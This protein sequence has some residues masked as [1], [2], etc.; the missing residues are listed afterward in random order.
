MALCF[1]K[2]LGDVAATSTVTRDPNG[3]Y[4]IVQCT[5]HGRETVIVSAHSDNHSDTEQADFYGRL[6]RSLPAHKVGVDYFF[7]LDAN[8]AP[9]WSLDQRNLSVGPAVS[10]QDRPL[11]IETMTTLFDAYHVV[12]SFRCLQP[13]AFES[14]RDNRIDGKLTCQKRLDRVYVSRHMLRPTGTPAVRS[15]RHLWPEEVDFSALRQLGSESKWSDHA[16]VACSVRYTNVPRAEGRWSMPLHIL[17]ELRPVE[18]MREQA[19]A[20]NS[21]GG[22]AVDNLTSLMTRASSYVKDRVE[23]GT[24]SHRKRKQQLIGRI[25][26]ANRLL[27]T[28]T[29]GELD[30]V[31]DPVE[32]QRRRD[33]AE[34]QRTDADRALVELQR[35]EQERWARD[36]AYEQYTQ[37]GTCSRAFFEDMRDARV[38][39]HIEKLRGRGNT[40]TEM[41][42]LLTEAKRYFGAPGSIFNLQRTLDAEDIR[43]RG[44]LFDALR[45]DNRVI[46]EHLRDKLR[47]EALFDVWNVQYAIEEMASSKTAG[48]DGI[49]ADWFKV[50]GK[51]V[52][53]PAEEEGEMQ[54][55]PSPLAD[56]MSR[57]FKQI[58]A[59]AKAPAC[60]RNAVVSLLYK[61]K[62]YRYDLKNYRPIAV[63]NAIGKILEKAMVISMRP[64]LDYIVSPEQK[65]FQTRKYIA[66][67]TQ[68]VQDVIAHCDNEKQDGMLV[69]CDQDSAY[70]R[71]EWEFMT[72]TM[73][74]MGVHEDFIKLVNI[75]YQDSTLQIKVNGH[76]GEA[77]SPTNSVAQ[78]S[79]LSPLL[80]LLVIQSFVSLLNVSSQLEEQHGPLGRIHGI[81]VPG[82]GGDELNTQQLR[83]LAFA[84]DIVCFL[85]DEDELPAFRQLL[86]VYE[87][88][89]GAQNSWPKTHGMRVGALRDSQHLPTGWV[90]GRDINTSAATVRYLGIFLGASERVA[91]EWEKK[92][93]AKMQQRYDRWVSRGAPTTRRGRNIVIRNHVNSLA[94]YLIQAQTP[95]QLTKMMD[96]WW[97]FDSVSR[98]F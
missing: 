53:S 10:K 47:V 14:T 87:R 88:G 21:A 22:N 27:G 55:E 30:A 83:V 95:P 97:R 44:I 52:K 46:P 40:Y 57:A 42:D 20:A 5:I 67:N 6:Q 29:E 64:L 91:K 84:D 85:R 24:R 39:S 1:A 86:R 12:D 38:Y 31:S 18:I 49:P 58:H 98:L 74:T 56:L 17:N 71:V 76:V 7:L 9:D 59:D 45:A 72:L 41:K 70:P 4:L 43:C 77:F 13:Y 90:E 26:T 36:R 15:T 23:K 60:M 82:I 65:A 35:S 32:R 73:R 66:E 69:F 2:E 63:A 51:R 28:H 25:R 54:D 75:M 80:Y 34:S 50:V 93:T 78:G 11:G 81:T 92:V 48:D 62:G 96:E 89:A 37:E 79:P 3:R 61:D 16:T 94:W 68:L 19:E 33:E 8:N